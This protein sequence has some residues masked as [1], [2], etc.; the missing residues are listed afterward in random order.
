MWGTLLSLKINPQDYQ[1]IRISY[2]CAMCV[3]SIFPS[4]VELKFSSSSIHSQATISHIL[5]FN[6]FSAA[7]LLLR[8]RDI[9][10]QKCAWTEQIIRR[11]EDIYRVCLVSR[12]EL[13]FRSFCFETEIAWESKWGNRSRLVLSIK[14]G[15][16]RIKSSKV[17]FEELISRRHIDDCSRVSS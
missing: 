17:K 15:R 1:M 4:F 14:V 16:V 3:W 5:E 10:S 7:R 11:I 6:F 12:V 8:S 13:R 9:I 2:L